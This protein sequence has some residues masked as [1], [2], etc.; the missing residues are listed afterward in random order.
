MGAQTGQLA[1]SAAAGG[2]GGLSR[3]GGPSSRKETSNCPGLLEHPAMAVLLED[4]FPLAGC[5]LR[6]PAAC[7]NLGVALTAVQKLSPEDSGPR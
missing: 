3:A 4:F 2:R 6:L 1:I 7:D 5:L